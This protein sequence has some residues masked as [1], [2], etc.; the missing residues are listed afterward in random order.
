MNR[1]ILALEATN[2]PKLLN[3]AG[4]K[5]LMFGAAFRGEF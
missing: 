3:Q 1:A 5:K 4:M 2:G